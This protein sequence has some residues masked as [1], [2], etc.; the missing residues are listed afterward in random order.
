MSSSDVVY[1]FVD[2]AGDMDFSVNG[3]KYYMF[4]HSQRNP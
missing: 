3:S 4:N 2:E 1:I